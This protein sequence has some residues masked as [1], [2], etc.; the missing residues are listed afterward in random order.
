MARRMSDPCPQSSFGQ[1]ERLL[2]A[3]LVAG[4]GVSTI[5]PSILDQY[6]LVASCKNQSWPRCFS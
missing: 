4:T 6:N 1:V 3:S 5:V 2:R